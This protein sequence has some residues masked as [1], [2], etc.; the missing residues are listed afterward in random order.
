MQR[1]REDKQEWMDAAVARNTNRSGCSARE[2]T[3]PHALLHTSYVHPHL[4]RQ[5]RTPPGDDSLA[6]SHCLIQLWQQPA[7]RLQS[8]IK[9][10]HLLGG[11]SLK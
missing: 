3:N 7:Q 9:G 1:W 6:V 4:R 2:A 10:S 8:T 5:I 11:G